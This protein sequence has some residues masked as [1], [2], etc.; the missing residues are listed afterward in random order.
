[1]PGSAP[2]AA[3]A[4]P[5]SP[6]GRTDRKGEL[7]LTPTGLQMW[8]GSSWQ[9]AIVPVSQLSAPVSV[10]PNTGVVT[11]ASG[12]LVAGGATADSLHITGAAAV[13]GLLTA[14]S[15][16][17]LAGANV[18]GG[19]TADATHISGG[20]TVTGGLTT[21]TAHATGAATVDGTLTAN[22]IAQ[23]SGPA[24]GT[25]YVQ[26][27]RGTT[28]S[29]PSATWTDVPWDF[30]DNAVLD[31]GPMLTAGSANFTLRGAGIYDLMAQLTF[32]TNATGYRGIR[33]VTQGV[34]LFDY[35]VHTASNLGGSTVSSH[36]V[37]Y[38][39]G[40]GYIVKVQ[41]YQD[42]GAALTV[43]ANASPNPAQA[44]VIQL[45]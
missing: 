41:V 16:R 40:N 9:A 6:L 18:A 34:T 45:G 10:D 27:H 24:R 38:F 8:D 42:S 4:T 2:F 13:D 25:N 37:G 23:G 32:T 15:L 31:D 1:M 17:A 29:V 21:D 5:A 7:R 28:L 43:L 14:N 44:S 12:L 20:A 19:L 11:L 30:V 35:Q 22:K 3:S 26:A 33:W 36:H 39:P